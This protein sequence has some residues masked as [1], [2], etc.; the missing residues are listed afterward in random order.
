MMKTM[1]KNMMEKPLPL[2]FPCVVCKYLFLNPTNLVC[3]KTLRFHQ[4]K[5]KM[6]HR[7]ILTNIPSFSFFSHLLFLFAMVT[8]P[9]THSP[10]PTHCAQPTST[11]VQGEVSQ[12]FPHQTMENIQ[13]LL[14]LA[15]SA[16]RS[17]KATVDGGVWGF[18][19]ERWKHEV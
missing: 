1:I 11:P 16:E 8:R 15:S 12:T 19:A 2:Y 10:P 5:K 13:L 7:H 14:L 18:T 17:T 3:F 4:C 6:F 9:L